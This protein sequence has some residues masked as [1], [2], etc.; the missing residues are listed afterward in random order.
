MQDFILKHRIIEQILLSSAKSATAESRGGF[1]QIFHK[2]R[3]QGR[4]FLYVVGPQG[5][6]RRR[7][8]GGTPGRLRGQRKALA[9]FIMLC[10]LG[11]GGVEA[12]AW[13]CHQVP[14]WNIRSYSIS[15]LHRAP[16][17][18]WGA[19]R[20]WITMWK[21]ALRHSFMHACSP[22]PVRLHV[23]VAEVLC[24]KLRCRVCNLQDLGGV[25]LGPVELF[26]H[27]RKVEPHGDVVLVGR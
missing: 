15:N 25:G 18:V 2:S 5:Q 9:F 23:R 19:V 17:P 16:P 12:Y 13:R 4:G 8:C 10:R 22:I 11:T 1:G 14:A 24:C 26:L 3:F 21:A 20:R 27:V 7:R 6:R